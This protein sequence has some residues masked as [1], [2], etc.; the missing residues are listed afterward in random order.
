VVQLVAAAAPPIE[1]IARPPWRDDRI[2]PNWP[3]IVAGATPDR[4]VLPVPDESSFATRYLPRQKVMLADRSAS[5]GYLAATATEWSDPPGS[6]LSSTEAALPAPDI[7]DF[8][9]YFGDGAT[10]T[11]IAE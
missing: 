9:S 6:A 8:L 11:S 4:T 2:D 5:A 3:M 10:V 7:E 1:A